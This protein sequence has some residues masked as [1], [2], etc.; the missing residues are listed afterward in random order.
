[1]RRGHTRSRLLTVWALVVFAFLYVPIGVVVVYAFNAN[2]QVALWTGFT[3]HWFGDALR[4]PVYTSALTTSLK[5]ALVSAVLSTVL[6]TAAALGLARAGRAA[7]LPFDTLVYLTLAVPEIVFAVAALIFF[8]QVRGSDPT[9]LLPSLGWITVALSHA[10]VGTS[11]VTLVVRARF[12]A[13]TSHLEEASFDLGAG[14]LATFRQITLPRLAPAALAGF[15]LA[16]VFSFDDY[17][18]TV[19][20]SGTTQTWPIVIYTSVRFGISP[21]VNA[22]AAL[23][24]LVTVAAM[25]LAAVVLRRSR[26]TNDAQDGLGGAFGFR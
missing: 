6:G 3:T 4:D 13:M 1:V 20:T 14:P 23:M 15:L 8:V 11:L 18:L 5:I 26:T 19:F 21:Q 10:V 25:V 2:R 22:L 7:R 12:V 16:F 24:L 9:G 17:V